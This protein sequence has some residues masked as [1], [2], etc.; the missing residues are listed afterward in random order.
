MNPGLSEMEEISD[1]ER[2]LEGTRAVGSSAY[3]PV[4]ARQATPD[5]EPGE[6]VESE[7]YSQRKPA[8]EP[9][10]SRGLA[11]PLVGM[12][13]HPMRGGSQNLWAEPIYESVPPSQKTPQRAAG[14]EVGGEKPSV[15]ERATKNRESG[16]PTGETLPAPRESPERSP[17]GLNMPDAAKLAQWCEE[18]RSEIRRRHQSKAPQGWRVAGVEV[19]SFDTH[20]YAKGEQI[21]EYDLEVVATITYERISKGTLPSDI[22]F[23]WSRDTHNVGELI[24]GERPARTPLA[25]RAML[26]Q[27]TQKIDKSLRERLSESAARQLLGIPDEDPEA[28]IRETVEEL[29]N[30]CRTRI[31]TARTNQDLAKAL[32]DIQKLQFVGVDSKVVVALNERL[33]QRYAELNAWQEEAAKKR[34]SS[35]VAQMRYYRT[36]ETKQLLGVGSLVE[37]APVK[38]LTKEERALIE[39]RAKLWAARQ[40]PKGGQLLSV[41]VEIQEP[42]EANQLVVKLPD[43]KITL[44]Y[45]EGI[46]ARGLPAERHDSWEI[47]HRDLLAEQIPEPRTPVVSAPLK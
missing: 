42:E 34:P 39:S 16:K 22:N 46:G 2:G 30:L 19:N 14:P 10:T 40:V 5:V 26:D 20:E 11:R 1:K 9:I 18:A 8:G 25:T 27:K 29:I 6:I 21:T 47:S 24:R 45:R 31:D 7:E 3:P 15:G 36:E 35:P 44:H 13:I 23:S 12:K 43:V 41:D 37:V 4:E 33:G 32:E 17:G 38:K 28:R